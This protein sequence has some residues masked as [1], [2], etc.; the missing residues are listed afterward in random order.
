MSQLPDD[1]TIARAPEETPTVV[2]SS[3]D[4][5]I[6]PLQLA[7]GAIL[8]G[9]YRIVSRLGRGGMGEVYR[10]DDLKLGQPIALKFLAKPDPARERELYDEVR[11]GRQISHPNLCRLYDIAEAEGRIFITM[12]LVDGEDLASLLRRIGRLPADKAVSVARDLCAGLAAA[13]ERGVIHRDLKPGNVMIDGR[14]RARITDFGL[15]VMEARSKDHALAGTPAYMAPEQLAGQPATIGSDI[16]ALGLLFYEIFTGR[17]AFVGASTADLVSQQRAMRITPPRQLVGDVESRVDQVILRCLDPDPEKR[18]E[19]VTEVM[20]ELPGFDPLDAAVAAGETPT[21]A[22]VAAAAEI[23]DLR[24]VTAWALLITAIAAIV[25]T[26]WLFPLSTLRGR[27]LPKPPDVML[28]RAREILADVGAPSASDSVWWFERGADELSQTPPIFFHYRQRPAAIVSWDTNDRRIRVGDPPL[29]VDGE[30]LM[31]LAHDGRLVELEIVPAR[32][33]PPPSR[34]YAWTALVGR[35]GCAQESLT[36]VPSEWAA[37]VDSDRKQAW[38][39]SAAHIEAASYHGRPVWLAVKP[40]LTPESGATSK[41][42][43]ATVSAVTIPFLIAVPIVTLLLA[44]RNLRR[45]RGDRRGARYYALFVMVTIFVGSILR[46]HHPPD[47]RA[48]WRQSSGLV[49]QAVF[50]G[51]MAGVIYLAVEPYV[52]RRWPRMLISL[53]RLMQGRPRDP[54]V[55]RDLLVGATAGMLL[56]LIAA[57]MAAVQ[58]IPL[59]LPATTLGGASQAL[60]YVT[61]NLAEATLRVI[62]TMAV[63][64]I[65]RTLVRNDVATAVLAVLFGTGALLTL[66]SG[67]MVMRVAFAALAMTLALALLFR[68]GVVAVTAYGFAFLTLIRLPLTLDPSLW[69]FGRSL[70]VMA[71]LAAIAVYGFTVAVSGRWLPRFA[72][73]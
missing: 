62:G 34:A 70:A 49:A 32:H 11:I 5:L 16:Y 66:M 72:L 64:L 73:D 3:N 67:S 23:G 57:S 17:R 9:R 48:I 6:A 13:H 26:A 47:L 44:R 63:L 12:E 40:A 2:M 71:L 35:A 8:G 27:A 20:R 19:S 24:P 30:L 58:K 45:G 28:E 33:D 36:P 46:A 42:A 1:P 53:T 41:R 54:M 39:A 14:G 4:E 60:Y 22:M 21:P 56:A 43:A 10:A 59:P 50:W 61:Y 65:L 55:G 25:T 38:R 68:F 15:A 7:P 29:N 31:T 69:Y 37:P 18:P 51:L 52:R